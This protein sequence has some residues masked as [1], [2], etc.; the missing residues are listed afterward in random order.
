MGWYDWQRSNE[1]D[2]DEFEDQANSLR[3]ALGERE[4]FV[5]GVA[6]AIE[7][8]DLRE[9]EGDEA[10][11]HK[12]VE[13]VNR[14]TYVYASPARYGLYSYWPR[15]LFYSGYG[16]HYHRHRL[17]WPGYLWVRR[18]R[19]PFRIRRR[20]GHHRSGVVKRHREGQFAGLM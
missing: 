19:Q 5:R 14:S 11:D 7:D 1:A 15:I 17:F 4:L 9:E 10:V 12:S 16:R 2:V 8:L 13:L 20:H 6:D 3:T 18:H